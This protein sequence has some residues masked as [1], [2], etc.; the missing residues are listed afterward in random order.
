MFGSL[1][2]FTAYK[3]VITFLITSSVF[4]VWVTDMFFCRL[5]P[6]PEGF[7][8]HLVTLRDGSG[9]VLEPT[10]ITCGKDY[11]IRN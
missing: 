5:E 1:G 11:T 4:F 6:Q 2:L 10:M 9:I 3:I 8:S 7:A